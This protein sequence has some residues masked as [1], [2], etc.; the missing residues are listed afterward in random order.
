MLH[1]GCCSIQFLSSLRGFDRDFCFYFS[2][3]SI[4][5]PSSK[6]VSEKHCERLKIYFVQQ[7]ER[8]F[9]IVRLSDWIDWLLWEWKCDWNTWQCLQRILPMPLPTGGCRWLMLIFVLE[10]LLL[11]PL[12][13]F[14]LRLHLLGSMGT[15]LLL[16][17][18]S[19]VIGWTV[20]F[21]LLSESLRGPDTV[22]EA[23]SGIT[24]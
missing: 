1:S 17:L 12:R 5:K 7:V 20:F 6:S 2:L 15:V 21:K 13:F 8:E 11:L 24:G 23:G 14:L 3:R 4:R 19:D 9:K 18:P 22:L 16:L 10:E